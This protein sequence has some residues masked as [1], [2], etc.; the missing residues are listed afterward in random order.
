MEVN[1]KSRHTTPYLVLLEAG[2]PSCWPVLHKWQKLGSVQN[3]HP[4]SSLGNEHVGSVR[5]SSDYGAQCQLR[6][7]PQS[8]T[9]GT[10]D[11]DRVTTLTIIASSGAHLDDLRSC[12]DEPCI[13][14]LALHWWSAQ[15]SQ[16][17]SAIDRV[18]HPS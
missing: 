14:K 1:R 7:G 3:I 16:F 9:R 15:L 18:Q 12:S 4:R 6:C 2:G 11:M 10:V 8:K 13:R 5:E 17:G